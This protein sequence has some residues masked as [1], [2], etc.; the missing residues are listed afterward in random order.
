MRR[1]GAA[2]LTLV[3]G[4]A[5]AQEIRVED[6]LGSLDPALVQHAIE[7]AGPDLQACYQNGSG[8]LRYVGG[9]VEVVVRV[10]R[11]G[12]IKRALVEASDL[13]SWEV[14][15]CLL[16]VAHK[17]PLP[18]PKGGDGVVR[19]PLDFQPS[20]PPGE[21]SDAELRDAAAKLKGIYRCAGAPKSVPV[22]LYVAAGGA[23]TSAGF[24]G[25]VGEKWGDC[26]LA[27]AK[28]VRMADPLGRVLKATVTP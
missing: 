17:L 8:G 20:T 18:R 5:A 28:A 26:A 6:G 12:H 27:R 23:V 24:A 19:I 16:G 15:R 21:M 14:E 2:L 22:T 7:A 11:A 9:H 3:C 25:G 10:D 4:V 13:G 1:A